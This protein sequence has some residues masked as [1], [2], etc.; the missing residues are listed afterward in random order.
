MAKQRPLIDETT[1]I[2]IDT[3][4]SGLNPK[5]SRILSIGAVKV[6]RNI[7]DLEEELELYLQPADQ[8]EP[9]SI[10]IHGILP[11]TAQGQVSDA[12]AA[13]Q[14]TEYLGNHIIV[15]H[16][17]AFD[18]KM[19]NQLIKTHTGTKLK[20]RVLDTG[21]LVKRVLAKNAYYSPKSLSLD[22][23]CEQFSIK[24]HDRHTAS[25]D[26]LLTSLLLLKIFAQLKKRG[27]VQTRDLFPTFSILGRH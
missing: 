14:L 10:P 4:T 13:Q 25:G 23:L 20:N 27:V 2:V 17:I 18:V 16:H 9:Q 19:M 26:A 24:M 15:G 8:Y 21:V 5:T 7:I 1:F 6:H 3:E 22:A 12:I 11:T